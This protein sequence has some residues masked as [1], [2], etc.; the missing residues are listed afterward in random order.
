MPALLVDE[1]DLLLVSR[2]GKSVRF[3]ATDEA[4]RPMGR[5]TSGV[6]GMKFRDGDELLVDRRSSTHGEDPDVFVVTEGGFAKRTA[7]VAVP[8]PGPR[9]SRHQGGQ[10]LRAAAA[11]SSAR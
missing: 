2:K 4:L 1:D 10:A 11:T 5:S 8:R 3:T 7:V 9:R 6:T